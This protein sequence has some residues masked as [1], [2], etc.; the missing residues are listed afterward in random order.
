MDIVPKNPHIT[1][2]EIADAL[3]IPVNQAKDTLNKLCSIYMNNTN[4]KKF[5]K[6]KTD[7]L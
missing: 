1:E 5:Y 7:D 3:E 6:L 2:K 4:K